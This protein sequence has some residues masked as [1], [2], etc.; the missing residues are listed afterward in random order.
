MVL[1]K[2]IRPILQLLLTRLFFQIMS[3]LDAVN[4]SGWVARLLL[5]LWLVLITTV[6]DPRPM[7]TWHLNNRI[8]VRLIFLFVSFS[9][10]DI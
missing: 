3:S 9:K 5:T 10:I 8:L 2:L 6:W 7:A 1:L 4:A